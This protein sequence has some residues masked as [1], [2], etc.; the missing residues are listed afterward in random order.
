[1]GNVLLHGGVTDTGEGVYLVP[2][3][4]VTKVFRR[5]QDPRDPDKDRFFN[6]FMKSRDTGGILLNEAFYPV[7]PI[8]V[9][10]TSYSDE[11]EELPKRKTDVAPFL[12]DM[13][14]RYDDN[15]YEY[16][17]TIADFIGRNAGPLTL[18]AA[19]ASKDDMLG[20]S[21]GRRGGLSA[22]IF[23]L[24]EVSKLR[25]GSPEGK[26]GGGLWLPREYD[27]STLNMGDLAGIIRAIYSTKGGIPL[28]G[29]DHPLAK[30]AVDNFRHSKLFTEVFS[31]ADRSYYDKAIS[32]SQLKRALARH[33]ME[34]VDPD[35]VN[36]KA[37]RYIAD[38]I[39]GNK[40]NFFADPSLE[41]GPYGLYDKGDQKWDDLMYDQMVLGLMQTLENSSSLAHTAGFKPEDTV[42]VACL[43][44]GKRILG[45][46]D[47]ASGKY[48]EQ[49][50]S[51]VEAV[52]EGVI[53]ERVM[54]D[55]KEM[56][57]AIRLYWK[58]RGAGVSGADSWK[59]AFGKIFSDGIFPSDERVKNVSRLSG[60]LTGRRRRQALK[61]LRDDLDSHVTSQA[62]VGG[63]KRGPGNG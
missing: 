15:G 33:M 8:P 13:N 35:A 53:P 1:M 9:E 52:V 47:M 19:A 30:A 4:Y 10:K 49:R 62:I 46:E 12:R 32:L 36:P 14:S 59:A 6:A 20:K 45:A 16:E 26:Y 7:D 3:S 55:F 29:D 61:Q 24:A 60:R 37:R 28:E 51:P 42:L 63:L 56:H 38:A 54:A 5:L 34:N 27:F 17:D 39:R 22:H 44:D 11:G 40:L 18:N 41:G 2:G 25:E 23:P 43:A 58:L 57:A 21:Y 31:D 48:T 50:D